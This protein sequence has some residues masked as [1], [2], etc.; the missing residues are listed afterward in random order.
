MEGLPE[1]QV[2]WSKRPG[3]NSTAVS[4]DTTTRPG[5]TAGISS[6]G[7]PQ[8]DGHVA[9]CRRRSKTTPAPGKHDLSSPRGII[10]CRPMSRWLQYELW[11]PRVA[12]RSWM[13]CIAANMLRVTQRARV[14]HGRE[15]H[16]PDGPKPFT[17]FDT[18]GEVVRYAL[19]RSG[20]AER[21]SYFALV[22]PCFGL[23]QRYRR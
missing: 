4:H 15:H 5:S 19:G 18:A 11:P 13:C 1:N 17:V 8:G 14:S 10:P 6:P 20:R 16:C 21:W 7:P 23:R 12:Q 9:R 3:H 22:P 2:G